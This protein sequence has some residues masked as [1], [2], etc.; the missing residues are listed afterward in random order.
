MLTE[1]IDKKITK[2]INLGWGSGK[3]QGT[4]FEHVKFKVFLRTLG[5]EGDILRIQRDTLA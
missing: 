3:D 4:N 5:I 2:D 1:K